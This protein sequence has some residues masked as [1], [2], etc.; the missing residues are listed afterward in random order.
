MTDFTREGVEAKL[1]GS[2]AKITKALDTSYYDS[3]PDGAAAKPQ[4]LQANITF[5]DTM[6]ELCPDLGVDWTD[7]DAARQRAVDYLAE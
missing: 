5:I 7:A 4:V 6:K 3:M 2:V 1:S